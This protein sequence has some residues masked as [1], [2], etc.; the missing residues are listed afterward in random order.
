MIRRKYISL[1]L[2]AL[3]LLA[4]GGAWSRSLACDCAAAEH[5][6][7]VAGHHAG[8]AH[9]A[10]TEEFCATCLCDRHS[11][12]IAL[13]TATTGDETPCRCAVLALP[14]GLAAAQA[15]RLAAPKYRKE[16]IVGPSLPL[17]PAP[18]LRLAGLRAPPVSA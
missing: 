13:Y 6:C 7:C 1:L 3:Y 12:D 15:A 9:D 10:A 5:L 14:H 2:L 8:H 4:T 17:P 16:R 18:C 11:T